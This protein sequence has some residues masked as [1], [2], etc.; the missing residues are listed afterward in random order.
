LG[1]KTKLSDYTDTCSDAPQIIKERF[2]ERNW[3]AM[4]ERQDLTLDEVELIVKNA[5]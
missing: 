5:L 3:T 4:G 2:E 1:I